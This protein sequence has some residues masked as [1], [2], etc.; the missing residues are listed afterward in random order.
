M[1][2]FLIICII[3]VAILFLISLGKPLNEWFERYL[4]NKEMKNPK[5]KE[6]VDEI[7][8]ELKLKYPNLKEKK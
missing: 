1:K 2:T 4:A 7:E 8:K 5:V 3:I 6:K